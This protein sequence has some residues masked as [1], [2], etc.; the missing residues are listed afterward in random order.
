[1]NG[2][3]LNKKWFT[4][5][6]L[7]ALTLYLI[8]VLLP[9]VWASIYSLQDWDGI[10]AMN[11]IGLQNYFE[12]LTDDPIFWQSLANTLVLMGT[13][14]VLIPAGLIMAIWLNTKIML[15]S[16]FKTVIFLPLVMP[17]VVL[18][19][20]WAQI[21]NPI[22]GLL[23]SAL[24]AFG[25]PQLQRAWLGEPETALLAI[26]V[27]VLWQSIGFYV[28]VYLA[29]LQNIPEEMIEAAKI[30]GA[31]DRVITL[32]II[33]PLL[34]NLIKFT[35]I[36]NIITSL[37]YFDL[38]FI[39]TRGQPDH[40]S[41]VVATH[42]YNQAFDLYNYGYASAIAFTLFIACVFLSFVL[43]RVF[44]RYDY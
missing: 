14:L 22:S 11:F 26:L 1:M 21:Y 2:K 37:K 17:S 6:L 9:I 18:G 43:N 29:G 32:Q 19:I 20:L 31:T 3:I 30:D 23:N 25:L 10:G 33:I 5:F 28:I 16:F 27:V 35:L 39:M 34:S 24:V 36:F 41:E 15:K 42:M 40:A 8:F 38:V 13:S 12:L 4:L 44:R 7:P